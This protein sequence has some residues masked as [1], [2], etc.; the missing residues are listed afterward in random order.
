M[1]PLWK[2]V[3]CLTLFAA[4]R[5]QVEFRTMTSRRPRLDCAQ[6]CP[7]SGQSY[8]HRPY[9]SSH[10]ETQARAPLL[11]EAPPGGHSVSAAVGGHAGGKA[12]CLPLAREAGV[13][14]A[15]GGGGNFIVSPLSIHAALA[16]VAAGTR[17]ETREELLGF[18]G[19]ASLDELHG[20]AATELAGRLNGLTQTSFACGVWVDRG[21]AL[22]PEF[23]A[24]A[25]SGYAA[26]A[27][28][29]DFSSDPEQARR[30]VNAFVAGATDGRIRDVLP[31]GS[32]GSSTRVV[33]AN[34]LYFNGTWSQPFD[35]S[36]TFTAPFHVPDGT[37]V[38]ASFMTTGR[39][40]FEQHVA[41]Y[42]GFRALKLPYKNDGDQAGRRAEA[43]FYMLLLLPDGG[44][45]LG[46]AD[47]YDK[48][49]AT[50]GFL[51]SH[52]PAVQVPVGRFMVPKFKFTFEFEA[53]S[54]MQKLGVTR[55]FEGGDFSGM[56][57]GG[58]GLFIAG[59]YHKATIEVDELGTVAAAA[60]A[61]VIF[62]SARAPRPPVDFVAN[63]P[64]LFA[65][66]EEKTSA[67]LF[68]GHVI[69]PLAE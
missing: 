42:P 64:F 20:A 57:S 15:A 36:A 31:P 66:V 65:I 1:S 23:M 58:D 62:Q 61:V 25:A 46:L 49:V 14:A 40:P 51:K 2:A 47:L 68:L 37:I 16:L 7:C 19:S 3:L 4:W 43:A 10:V 8:L 12:S 24:T 9:S 56:V 52:T 67:V 60:T 48:A 39:F 55:A 44:A 30:R 34:A 21:Q 17:G 5:S 6:R 35:Q 13:R 63:R 69:N 22:E 27:E 59:V 38:R 28:S 32:V 50:P 18:L 29:V 26:T 33:L 53:S 45:A 11:T 41:V 54:D